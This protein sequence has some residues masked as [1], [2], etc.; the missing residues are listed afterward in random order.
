[1]NKSTTTHSAGTTRRR[2]FPLKKLG[3]L[4]GCLL[5][6][7][8]PVDLVPEALLPIAG[9]VDDVALLVFAV[10][11]LRGRRRGEVDSARGTAPG[12]A[13]DPRRRVVKNTAA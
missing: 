6:L 12:P 7:V 11:Q 4:A 2:R 5:Y 3:I 10:Q 8:S 1:M 9:Y 13:P